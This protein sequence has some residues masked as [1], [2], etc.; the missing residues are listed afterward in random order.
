MSPQIST[1]YLANHSHTDLGFT[2][3]QDV[4]FRQHLEFIDRAIELC[5][6]TADAPD[7]SR[8]R[9]VCEGT[10][11]TER[12]FRQAG[13]KQVERFL[14]CHQRGQIDVTAMQWNFTPSLAPEQMAR[15]L[16]PVRWLR[17]QFGVTI[18][19]AMQSDSNGIS[20]MFADLLAEAGIDFLT[21]SVNPVRGG[22]P[23]P[24]P[25]A[26]WW[27]G[28]TGRRTLTWNGFHYLFARSN[29]K[30]GDWRYVD[31]FF[32]KFLQMLEEDTGYPWDF[33]Y[34]QSTHPIRV[35]NGPP[36]IRM[37]DF[38]RE[39]NEQGRTPRLEFSTPSLF[40]RVLAEHES[41]LPVM[42]GDW[43]D[44]WCDGIASSAFES[45]V[46]RES[47]N[48]LVAAETV[49]SWAS[50][51]T[52]PAVPA[53]RLAHVYELLSLYD[54]HTWGAFASVAAP[55]SVWSKGQWNYKASFAY[56]GSGET[57]DILARS[58]RRL[59]GELADPGPEGRFNVGDLTPD[60]AYPAA[61]TNDLLV[62]NTLPWEREV[63]VAEPE[64][65][66]GAAPVGVLEAFFP[67]GVPW[68]GEK[69]P[70][71]DRRKRLRLPAFGYVFADLD[72]PDVSDDLAASGQTIE[73]EHYRV[74][75][76][77][78]TGGLRSLYDK[79]L[80][81]ELAGTYRGWRLG[82]LIY[83]Q[84]DDST[85]GYDAGSMTPGRDTINSGWDFSQVPNFG[86]WNTDVRF[87]H[88]VPTDVAV[89]IPVIEHG[90]VSISVQCSITGVRWARCTYWL[91]TRTRH[92]GIDWEL[93]KEHVCDAEELFV[94][95]PTALG[96]PTFRGDV[97][98]VPFSPD[99]DQLPGT[100]RD[101]FPVRGWFDVSDGTAGVTVAPLDAPLV[102]LG[103]ITTA[104][105]AERLAP[106]APAIMSWALN[107]HWMVNFKAS[108][109][110]LI[111]LRY[112]LTTH[113]GS[114]HDAAAGRFAEE[115]HT[116]PIVLRDY[117][118]TVADAERSYLALDDA[119]VMVH[120]KESVT[121]DGGVIL[122]IRSLV[123]ES[124]AVRLDV[125]G[126]QPTE[127]HRVSVLETP[128]GDPVQ[129]VDGAITLELRPAEMTAVLL[130]RSTGV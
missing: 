114:V 49:A 62:V 80:D 56:R 70:T 82:Q 57:H 12:W 104:K 98:G 126:Y 105:A 28:P 124:Q 16:Y 42:R 54:E 36:D 52:H 39:W 41:T 87:R 8:Y 58:A 121:E 65:R 93:D 20:W 115:M 38:V 107:N 128:I 11:V 7:E 100:V 31:R 81:R 21:M 24:C 111:P 118:R 94:A 17:E 74:E 72:A 45:G 96:E 68:G 5:E 51:D 46:N 1:V 4:V 59:A 25:Q 50:K 75:V 40:R 91:D 123:R 106:E 102:Q 88:E 35:D 33:L 130:R 2:D 119:D 60:E 67:R 69:P 71:P 30:L 43:L 120:A 47:H 19:S 85:P 97:N 48:L 108:Q 26:F 14:A 89:G 112:R 55:D 44:W 78:Q 83:Q 129:V 95:F 6:Y 53:E 27:E 37:I 64:L 117:S 10:G 110:G 103:G 23:K 109:G 18:S 77:P 9:W 63:F 116:P 101:W 15:S 61:D 79:R 92:L 99:D 66:G 86:A 76:D 22:V 34:C 32:P 127:A 3:H 73:N 122:R 125:S 113:E 84:V 90:R 29:A 13:D